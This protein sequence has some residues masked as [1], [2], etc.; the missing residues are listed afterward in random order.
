MELNFCVVFGD[1]LDLY[2]KYNYYFF[3]FKNQEICAIVDEYQFI[4][5]SI[6]LVNH[7][8]ITINKNHIIITI[9]YQQKSNSTNYQSYKIQKAYQPYVIMEILSNVVVLQLSFGASTTT[10]HLRS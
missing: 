2:Y 4:K 1:D 9:N 7:M 6:P 10:N 8:V 3:L 5:F